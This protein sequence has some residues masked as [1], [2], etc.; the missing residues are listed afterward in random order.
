M[1]RHKRNTE[2][3]SFPQEG[4]DYTLSHDTPV[5]VPQQG[6]EEAVTAMPEEATDTPKERGVLSETST[7]TL[8]GQV[9]AIDV[10]S[11]PV[12]E[13]WVRFTMVNKETDEVVNSELYPT[14]QRLK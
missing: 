14:W 8:D 7:I 6:I 3:T 1:E 11:Q 4:D 12:N 5:E 2:Y 9:V 13:K 10:Y